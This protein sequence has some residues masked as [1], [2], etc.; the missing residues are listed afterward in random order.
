MRILQWRPGL[1]IDP[2]DPDSSRAYT[3]D[4]SDWL[5][6]TGNTLASATV[7]TPTGITA[8]ITST[9]DTSAVLSVS[10]GTIEP[11]AEYTDRT[12][13]VRATF[14][15]GQVDDWSIVFRVTEK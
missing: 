11:G 1:R 12:V 10:G 5:G 15:D 14:S 6:T 8:S 7:P 3:I 9:D 13:T 4:F 2:L